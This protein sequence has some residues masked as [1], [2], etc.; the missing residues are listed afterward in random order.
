[1]RNRWVYPSFG[2]QWENK[3]SPCFSFFSFYFVPPTFLPFF[4]LYGLHS[5]FSKFKIHAPTIHFLFAHPPALLEQWN[6]NQYKNRPGEAM[7]ARRTCFVWEVSVL[8]T[9]NVRL[10]SHHSVL[11]LSF[12]FW[13]LKLGLPIYLK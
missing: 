1:M 9:Q 12:S 10:T 4:S 3:S 7:R 2:I 8:C 11:F 6:D 5:L 13:P